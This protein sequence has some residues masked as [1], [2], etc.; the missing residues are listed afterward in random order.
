MSKFL[1]NLLLQMSKA[2]VYSKIKFYSEKSFSFTFG[3]SGLSAQPRPIFF[4]FNLPFFSPPSPLGLGLSAGPS[5]PLGLA[6]RASVAPCWIAASHKGKHLTSR[7][8]R[9][10]PCLAGRWAPPIITFLRRHPSSTPHRRL[11]EPPW[12]P[13]PPLR[14]PLFMADR[15]HSLIL[16]I[17]TITTPNSSSPFL[18]STAGCYRVHRLG[19]PPPS[20]PINWPPRP[21]GSPHLPISLFPLSQSTSATVAEPSLLRRFPTV[22]RS[23]HRRLIPGEAR[24]ELPSCC[25]APTGELPCTRVAGGQTP[26]STPPRSGAF[27]LRHRRS[28]VDR[29]PRPRSITRGPG[30]RHYPLK[31]SSLF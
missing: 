30:P 17:I 5:R 31:N 10:S 15:Y 7:R 18:I 11:I 27:G 22:A 1:L 19:A 9:P 29:A 12:L 28:T 26:V 25:C 21:Y 6:D 4:L 14:P 8:L 24:A 13:C 16:A 2:L 3:P 23:P 20:G